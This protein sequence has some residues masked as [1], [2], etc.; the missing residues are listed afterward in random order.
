MV[1]HSR[2][3]VTAYRMEMSVDELAADRQVAE[4]LSRLAN[5][6]GRAVPAQR[7]G[8]KGPGAKG[9]E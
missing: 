9:A 8:G 2:L 1:V 5:E 7:Q 4:R 6:S 3:G